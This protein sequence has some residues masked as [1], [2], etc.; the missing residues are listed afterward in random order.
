MTETQRQLMDKAQSSLDAAKLLLAQGFSDFAAARAY[1]SMLYA[2][3]AALAAEGLS[4][5][6]HGAV[7]SAFGKQLANPGKV[8]RDLHRWLLDSQELRYAG[9]Y[10]P[11]DRVSSESAQ[12]EIAHAEEFIREITAF[13]A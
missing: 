12:R 4:F 1:Y 11:S 3:S 8:S 2:A 7:A 6:S 9:D 10:L 13:L 5:K